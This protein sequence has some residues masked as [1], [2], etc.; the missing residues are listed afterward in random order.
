MAFEA[1]LDHLSTEFETSGNGIHLLGSGN[2]VDSAF[3]LAGENPERLDTLIGLAASPGSNTGFDRLTA[4]PVYLYVGEMDG[5]WIGA[6]R[7]TS[8]ALDQAGVSVEVHVVSGDGHFLAS[9]AGAGLMSDLE[10]LRQR[11]A[12]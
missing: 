3:R 1:L 5:T 8:D 4:V 7:S 10:S 6:V 11:G 2:G 9:L 12:P